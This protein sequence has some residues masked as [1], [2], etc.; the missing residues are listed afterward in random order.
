MSN[1]FRPVRHAR[2]AQSNFPNPRESGRLTSSRIRVIHEGRTRRCWMRSRIPMGVAVAA[3]A[4]L[5]SVSITGQA[6]ARTTAAAKAART[7]DGPPDFQGTY[8]VATLTPVER[9][10]S[11]R[12]KLTLTEAEAAAIERT[13]R[14]RVA[15]RALPSSPDRAAPPVGAN[16]GG[17]NNFWID[18]G[19]EAMIVDGQRRTSLIVD[20]PDGKI[21]ATLPE[22]QKRNAALRRAA[23]T[24]DAPESAVVDDPGAFDDPELRPLG[25]RCLLGFGST[26]GP[27]TLPNYFYNNLKQIVQTPDF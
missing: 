9:P 1:G 11:A 7:P 12:G 19:S 5:F 27:P 24:S 21:P 15:Q 18:R 8:N 20:P 23:P 25:E 6:P 26:S 16:V 22:A 2:I 10:E 17:Y 13:E 3:V 14:Q 4:S